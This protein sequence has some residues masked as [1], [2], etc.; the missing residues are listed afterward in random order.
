MVLDSNAPGVRPDF[1]SQRLSE[2]VDYCFL[3]PNGFDQE[4]VKKA[5]NL[6]IDKDLSRN[7]KYDFKLLPKVLVARK[8]GM[9]INHNLESNRSICSVF[10]GYHYAKLLG[11]SKWVAEAERKNFFTPEDHLRCMNPRWTLVKKF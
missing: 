1:L 3:V 5:V 6:A 10:T 9:K 8:L 7:F 2:Y 11:E 4:H